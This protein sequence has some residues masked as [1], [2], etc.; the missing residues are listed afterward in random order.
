MARAKPAVKC[1]SVTDI[2]NQ[3]GTLA[4]NVVWW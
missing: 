4:V 1:V 3:S 2:C